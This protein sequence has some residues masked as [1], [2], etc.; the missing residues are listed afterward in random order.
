MPKDRGGGTWRLA[1]G[2]PTQQ[3]RIRGSKHNPQPFL[4]SVL[5]PTPHPGTPHLNPPYFHPRGGDVEGVF[6]LGAQFGH[7][8][9]PKRGEE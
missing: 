1:P 5:F 6:D 8:D 4:P 9:E 7:G 3:G 2:A